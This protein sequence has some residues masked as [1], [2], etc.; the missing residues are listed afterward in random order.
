[1]PRFVWKTDG[2]LPGAS[3]HSLAKLRLIDFYLQRYF[4]TVAVNPAMDVLRIT[5]VDGFCGGGAYSDR[6]TTVEGSPLVLIGAVEKARRALNEGRTK[7]IN[8]DAQ[9][10]LVDSDQTAIDALRENL[11]KAGHLTRLG[12]DIHLTRAPFQRA[13]PDIKAA[14][15]A[16]TRGNVGRSVFVLDQKGYTDAPLPLVKDILESFSGCEVILTFAVGWLIDYLSDKPQTLKAVA[17]LGLS[18]GQIREYLQLKDQ[19]G[20]RIVIERLL[21]Q[22]LRRETGATFSSPFFIRS[23]EANKDLWIIHLSNHVTARNVMVE[24]HWLIKN[25]SLHFGTGDFEMMGFD[26]HLDPASTPDFWFGDYEQELMRERLKDGV[27]KR[28]RDRYA[29]ESVEYLTFLREA[30]NET[31]AR[32]ADFDHVAGLLVDEKQLKLATADGQSRRS[33]RPDRRDLIGI[34]PQSSFHFIRHSTETK[35]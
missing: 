6:G 29:S 13:F 31:P 34:H 30:A 19:R 26:P 16:R 18:E 20:G 9:F 15:K 24:G 8:I 7:P 14:I 22:H 5:F 28:L 33:R 32:L 12:Q 23:V 1:M 27:L 25:N 17:P 10:Y 2:T 35:R 11:A 3:A 21:Q 4:E